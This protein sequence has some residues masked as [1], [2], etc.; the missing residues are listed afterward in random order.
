MTSRTYQ[1]DDD[2]RVQEHDQ[3]V[4]GNYVMEPDD[5]LVEPKAH[6]VEPEADLAATEAPLAEPD[7]DLAV[8]EAPVADAE[9]DQ[10]EAEGAMSHLAGAAAVAGNGSAAASAPAYPAFC[11]VGDDAAELGM[12]DGIPASLQPVSIVTVAPESVAESSSA[13]DATSPGGPWNEVQAMFVDDPAH[14]RLRGHAPRS[15]ASE[16]PSVSGTEAGVQFLCRWVT[17][18]LNWR[19]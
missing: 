2:R 5:D 9:A 8:S 3:T 1:A 4:P 6:L 15:P 14:M 11:S 12:P 16:P 7:A 19:R 18:A 17:M 10:T 13:G